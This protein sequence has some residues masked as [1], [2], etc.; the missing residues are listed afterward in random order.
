MKTNV[1][2]KFNI[3]GDYFNP[4]VVTKRLNLEPTDSYIKGDK[5][6]YKSVTRK[7]TCWSI[8]T[9]Y[10]E[11]FDISEQINLIIKTVLEKKE[12][13][14]KLR[15]Q[16]DVEYF[17]IVIINIEDNMGPAM[18]FESPIIEFANYIG[19]EIHVDYYINSN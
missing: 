3:V 2:V 18:I 6:R 10:Y 7:E 15:S 9:G 16:L 5:G 1:N 19:A 17:F 13:L 8:E 12:I 14:K 4:D 11:S